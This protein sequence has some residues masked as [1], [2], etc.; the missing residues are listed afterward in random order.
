MSINVKNAELVEM[1]RLGAAAEGMGQT[2]YIRHAVEHLREQSDHNDE[3]R[4]RRARALAAQL[5]RSVRT[6]D[7]SGAVVD[8]DLYAE[9]GL[10]Q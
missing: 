2:A 10:P 8:A 4:R 5:A 9:D 3:R 6:E 7:H 1:I